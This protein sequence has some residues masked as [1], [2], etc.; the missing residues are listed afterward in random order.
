MVEEIQEAPHDVYPL[1]TVA[2]RTGLTPDVIRAWERRYGVVRP[3]RGP[4]GARLY[5]A[6]DI[7]LLTLLGRI[8]ASGRAIGDVA[9]MSRR[10]LEALARHQEDR[11]RPTAGDAGA[12]ITEALAAL[13]TFDGERVARCLGDALVALGPRGFVLRVAVP[14]VMEVGERWSRGQ[15]SVADEHLLSAT[16]RSLLVGLVQARGGARGPALLLATVTGE[17]HEI[18][19]LL[20]ALLAVDT[21]MRLIY[22]GTDLPAREIV[23]AANRSKPA[24]VGI[25]TVSSDNRQ[26]AVA[27]LRCLADELPA[28]AQ[29]WVGGRDAADVV[30]ACPGSR[31]QVMGELPE[32]EAELLRVRGGAS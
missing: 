2:G 22:L 3:L 8:V 5:N 9:R 30:A 6:D 14:L 26:R 15:L 13:E 10:D 11:S 12:V 4:R 21:G 24:V 16:L 23:A 17:R 1:R 18:G 28:A 29:L 25:S 19:L 32:F 7:Y 31:G 27:E 20:A